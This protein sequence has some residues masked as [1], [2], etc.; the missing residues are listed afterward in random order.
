MLAGAAAMAQ[1]P[2]RPDGGAPRRSN[3]DL[4]RMGAGLLDNE[5]LQHQGQ[6]LIDKRGPLA[7][8]DGGAP[9][10]GIVAGAAASAGVGANEDD[11]GVDSTA[12]LD[13]GSADGGATSDALDGGAAAATDGD[14]IDGGEA[15][16][17]DGGASG[18]GAGKAVES[19][20][21]GGATDPA[22]AAAAAAAAEDARAAAHDPAPA[23]SPRGRRVKSGEEQPMAGV[24]DSPLTRMGIPPQAVPAVATAAAAS[25][26][27]IWP[28]LSKTVTGLFKSFLAAKVKNRGKKG[29]TFD[30]DAFAFNFFGFRIRPWELASLLIAAVVYGLAVSYVFQ[31]WKMQRPFVLRQEGLVIAIYYSRSMVRFVY[32]RVFRLATQYKFWPGGAFLCLGVAYLGNTFGTVGF[33]VSGQTSKEDEIRVSK[34]KAALIV[35]ALVMAVGFCVANLHSPAKVLQSG[36]SMM[37]GMALGEIMPIDPMPGK[38]IMGWNKVAW[39]VLAL[40]VVPTFFVINFYL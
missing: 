13:A 4:I 33:E 9:A 37:S 22:A 14:G 26:M 29:Q 16:A 15:R 34:M 20:A 30:P 27:A 3:E 7:K 28:I 19:P 35:L 10:N 2:P 21:D 38:K 12:A 25:A 39:A 1:A 17:V 31:G 40:L 36:R 24:E 11:A 18:T 5:D 6:G 32:E 23:G 8:P